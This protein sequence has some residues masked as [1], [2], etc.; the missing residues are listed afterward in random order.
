MKKLLA[1]ALAAALSLSLAACGGGSG[2]GDT[3]TPSGGSGD[4]TRTDTPNDG[5]EVDT[6]S[7]TDGAT[8]G[9]WTFRLTEIEWGDAKT[10]ANSGPDFLL[11][12]D[13]EYK[14]SCK[15]GSSRY[16]Q[17][18]DDGKVFLFFAGTLLYEGKTTENFS[19]YDIDFSVDYGDGYT[20]ETYEFAIAKDT[21]AFV[22]PLYGTFSNNVTFE[23]MDALRVC[24]GYFE[25]PSKISE[26]VDEQIQLIV[27]LKGEEFTYVFPVRDAY[28]YSADPE[29]VIE[30]AKIFGGDGDMLTA[31]TENSSP[32]F[33]EM[34]PIFSAMSDD[35]IK[36][37]IVGRWDVIGYSND[38][39]DTREY[40]FEE[41]GTGRKQSKKE[42]TEEEYSDFYWSVDGC[43]NY[44]PDPDRVTEQWYMC[45]AS[46]DVLV[47]YADG[48]ARIVFIKG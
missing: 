34:K 22:D 15:A 47:G 7:L 19:A 37:T 45:Q 4:T 27:T 40:I 11:R 36:E 28:G 32:Y 48:H 18:A 17:S 5:A 20:F 23:P 31:W 8:V 43:L 38:S 33:D 24:R 41:E 35:S 25:L 3:N 29:T 10:G 42:D 13:A 21:G 26:N 44:G 39:G 1:L 12:A 14:S 46:D 6:L 9:D 30:M 16:Y 2:T